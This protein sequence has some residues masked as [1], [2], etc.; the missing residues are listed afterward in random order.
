MS[1][2]DSPLDANTNEPERASGFARI[3]LGGE[4]F[5]GGRLPVDALVEIERYR[6]ML[7]AMAAKNWMEAHPNKS[8]PEDFESTFDIAIQEVRDGSAES[9]LDLAPSPYTTYFELAVEDIE[10]IF[11]EIVEGFEFDELPEAAS[12]NEL[13]LEPDAEPADEPQ[14]DDEAGATDQS[15]T[16]ARITSRDDVRT[17][18]QLPE[19]REFG[20]SLHADEYA[21]IPRIGDEGSSKITPLTRR[22]VI[23]PLVERFETLEPELLVEERTHGFETV[24]GRLIALN[25]DKKNYTIRTLL[26]GTVNGRY[27]SSSLLEDLKDVLNSSSQAPVIRLTGRV[28]R[29]GGRLERILEATDVEL[30]EIEGEPWSRRFIELASLP[31]GWDEEEPSNV[32]SF[33]AL[34]AARELI[35]ATAQ[36][37]GP[38]PG[39]SPMADGGVHVQWIAPTGAVSVEIDPDAGFAL[40]SLLVENFGEE[41]EERTSRYLETRLLSEAIEFVSGVVA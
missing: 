19:F 20:S 41:S 5:A 40:Q 31:S 16:A 3:I 13:E 38:F 11:A 17:L 25:A 7:L 6:A 23:D 8:L 21:E 28:S 2:Q 12:L 15:K 26:D 9:V 30:F 35:R 32:I 29:K 4:R 10:R 24:A 22:S 1:E 39:I 18:V 33:T 37:S 36:E 14:V 34:D 27:K